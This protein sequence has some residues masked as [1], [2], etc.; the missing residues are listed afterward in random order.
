MIGR[1]LGLKQ[2]NG[3]DVS[4]LIAF[5]DAAKPFIGGGFTRFPWTLPKT[6]REVSTNKRMISEG[7]Q[8]VH[9]TMERRGQA[10]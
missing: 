9:Y 4:M 5:A 7:C 1:V 10:F 8:C 3:T 6:W 2:L